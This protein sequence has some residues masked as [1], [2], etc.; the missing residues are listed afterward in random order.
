[1]TALQPGR[2]SRRSRAAVRPS[3]PGISMSSRATAG[4]TSRAAGT[5]SAP[6]AT[7]ATTSN[8]GLQPPQAGEGPPHHALVLGQK[9]PDHTGPGTSTAAPPGGGAGSGSSIGIL[10]VRWNPP[11][12]AGPA[13]SVPPPIA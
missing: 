8:V 3:M 13:S 11:P 2:A 10:A 9:D 6:D 12:R 5:T 7:W 4:L 1:M